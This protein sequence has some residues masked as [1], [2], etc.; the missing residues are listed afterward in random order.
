MNRVLLFIAYFFFSLLVAI[1][2]IMAAAIFGIGVYEPLSPRAE[3]YFSMVVAFPVFVIIC[4][5]GNY[6]AQD[7]VFPRLPALYFIIIVYASIFLTVEPTILNYGVV[8]IISGI[9]AT[10]GILCILPETKSEKAK[11]DS[12]SL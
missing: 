11:N 1:L 3:L 7:S 10:M 2:V 4:A 12:L 6:V 8:A 9:I 5:I